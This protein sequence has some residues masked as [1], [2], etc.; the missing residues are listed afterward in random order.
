MELTTYEREDN[1][2]RMQLAGSW[3]FA[4]VLAGYL[5]G[6]MAMKSLIAAW[7]LSISHRFRAYLCP[8]PRLQAVEC[9]LKKQKRKNNQK[10]TLLSPNEHFESGFVSRTPM[11]IVFIFYTAFRNTTQDYRMLDV[12]NQTTIFISCNAQHKN[13][14]YAALFKLPSVTKCFTRLKKS[15]LYRLVSDRSRSVLW[16]HEH[17]SKKFTSMFWEETEV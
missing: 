13:L 17:C 16:H 7:Q 1:S 4:W 2:T 10:A 12:K 6:T 9:L 14:D 8:T 11:W 15:L 3:N 5:Q